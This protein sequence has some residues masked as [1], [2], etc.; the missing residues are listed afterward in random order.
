MYVTNNQEKL[1]YAIGTNI[2]QHISHVG[3]NENP[4]FLWVL[5]FFWTNKNSETLQES[6]TTPKITKIQELPGASPPG[7][8]G[9]LKAAPRSHAFEEKKIHHHPNQNSWIRP[10]SR[11]FDTINT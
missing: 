5:I 10:C 1:L 11:P 4:S 7:P 2:F 8:T 6:Q 9:G 3:L